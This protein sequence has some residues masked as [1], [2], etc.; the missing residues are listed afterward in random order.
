MKILLIIATTV[1]TVL[2]ADYRSQEQNSKTPLKLEECILRMPGIDCTEGDDEDPEPM[3]CGVI[4][5]NTNFHNPIYHSCVEL[6]TT[7]G[8]LVATI[9]SDINGHYF[10]NRVSAGSYNL[11]VSA[12]GYATKVVQ[13]TLDGTPQTIDVVLK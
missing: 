11:V 9:G 10:F 2:M 5:D 3:M 8:V 4:T 7:S 12:A 6:K 13:V 1:S